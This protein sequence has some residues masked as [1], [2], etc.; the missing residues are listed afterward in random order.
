ME[1]SPSHSKLEHFPVTLLPSVM[2][3]AGL[4]I[5]YLKFQHEFGI[6]APIGQGILFTV[7]AWFA[8]LMAI[9]TI[10]LIRYP[11][12]V[13]TDFN[14][15]I[16]SNFFPAISISL[17]LLCIGY[18]EIGM[19]SAANVLWYIATPLHLFLL[20]KILHDWFFK[21]YK[22][23]T[24]NPAWFI[25]VVGPLLVPIAGV[26][27]ASP[28]ISWFFY[29]TG[30]VFWIV[31]LAVLV[32]RIFFQDPMPKKLIPTLFILIAPPSVG[33]ISYFKLSHSLDPFARILF[34]FG[35]FTFLML[36][37]MVRKFREVPFFLSWWA[38][39]FP[40]ASFTISNF[41]MYKITEITVFRQ[42]A[43][44]MT[45]I[46]TLTILFVLFKSLQ[47]AFRGG[48]CVVEE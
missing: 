43:F 3:L 1:L 32:G 21:T 39:T 8:F 40:L 42:F 33:F 2:G 35:V 14:H 29:A 19:V 28:E 10:R 6:S 30:I 46:T 11:Q 20:L 7:S 48:I 15:P 41:L 26:Q 27:I 5:V 45:I 17:L 9:Q 38:Y 13:A 24:F 36:L 23:N 4:A 34:Y 12:A 18:Q 44:A 22:I 25:P 16:R 47:V 37:T 31:L